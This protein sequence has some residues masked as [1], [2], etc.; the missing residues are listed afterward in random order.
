MWVLVA[1]YV[2]VIHKNDTVQISAPS[3]EAVGDNGRRGDDDSA[4]A[5]AT[6]SPTGT[7][8]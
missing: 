3:L 6:E 2:F 5:T 1:V 4:E 7:A 8:R